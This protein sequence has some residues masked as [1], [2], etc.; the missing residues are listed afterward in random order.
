MV[1]LYGDVCLERIKYL[2]LHCSYVVPSEATVFRLKKMTYLFASVVSILTN[3]STPFV[4]PYFISAK[5]VDLGRKVGFICGAINF[6]VIVITFFFIPEL[7]SRTLEEADQLFA[8]GAALRRFSEIRTKSATKIYEE[9]VKQGSAEVNERADKVEMAQRLGACTRSAVSCLALCSNLQKKRSVKFY[10]SCNS[11]TSGGVLEVWQFKACW[12]PS[13][14]HRST[15]L[16]DPMK[17]NKPIEDSANLE[18]RLC[19][20][21]CFRWVFL[22]GGSLYIHSRRKWKTQMN[23]IP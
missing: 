17:G 20:M 8:G 6:V 10:I 18:I 9:E 15:R 14:K 13:L 3:L 22:K 23:I 19:V 11:S 1:S 7:K 4:I 2:N 5:Y 21:T 16:V 12:T